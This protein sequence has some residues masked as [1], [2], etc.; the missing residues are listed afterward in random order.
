[1]PPWL[2]SPHYRSSGGF[3]CSVVC[4]RSTL[5]AILFLPLRPHP[6]SI[7]SSCGHVYTSEIKWIIKSMLGLIQASESLLPDSFS[8]CSQLTA[9]APNPNFGLW[10]GI[11]YATGI[12]SGPCYLVQMMKNISLFLEL[13]NWI[14]LNWVNELLFLLV[15][16]NDHLFSFEQTTIENL[17]NLSNDPNNYCLQEF[18]IGHGGVLLTLTFVRTSCKESS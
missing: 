10:V 9:S 3:L 4:F 14:Y 17:L 11:F 7:A 12:S 1:M 8:C 13:W 5:S 15:A 6:L 2:K 18:C 16:E